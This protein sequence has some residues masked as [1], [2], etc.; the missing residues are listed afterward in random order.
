MS[1][2]LLKS[3][4]DRKYTFKCAQ[5]FTRQRG[6]D[7]ELFQAGWVRIFYRIT[8]AE[9]GG[10]GFLTQQHS[11]TSC[12]KCAR[13]TITEVQDTLEERFLKSPNNGEYPR[14]R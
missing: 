10:S 12:P 3:E 5:C 14:E 11:L 8:L 7:L 9:D 1:D 4:K 6:T 13:R 2:V